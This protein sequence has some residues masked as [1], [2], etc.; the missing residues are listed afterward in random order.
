[1]QMQHK[2]GQTRPPR[3]Q[4]HTR[5]VSPPLSF[6]NTPVPQINIYIYDSCTQE[7][8]I[9]KYPYKDC[10]PLLQAHRYTFFLFH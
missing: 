3:R 4:I 9:N 6:I 8:I 1:M 7:N 10:S 5:F 2:D